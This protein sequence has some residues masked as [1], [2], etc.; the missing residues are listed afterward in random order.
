MTAELIYTSA[1]K[2]LKSGS[3]GFCTVVSSQGMTSNLAQKLESLSAYRQLFPPDSADASKNPISFSHLTFRVGGQEYSVLSRVAAYGTDYSGRTNKIAHHVIPGR[4]EQGSEGPAWILSQQGVMQESWDGQCRNTPQGPSLPSGHLETKVCTGW[5]RLAGDPGWA[6]V[7]AEAWMNPQQK[8]LTV[9][10]PLEHR[11]QSLALLREATALL[12]PSERWRATFCT[13]VTQLPPDVKC[14]VRFVVAGSPDAIKAKAR[15][16]V[17]EL[18]QAN[19]EPPHSQWVEIARGNKVLEKEEPRTGPVVS[20]GSVVE[21]GPQYR[22]PGGVKPG[23][24]PGVTPPRG[25]EKRGPKGPPVQPTPPDPFGLPGPPVPPGGHVVI[26][27]P[28]DAGGKTSRSKS[29]MLVLALVAVAM[30]MFVLVGGAGL[31]I[32]KSGFIQIAQNDSNQENESDST[33]IERDSSSSESKPQTANNESNSGEEGERKPENE[34]DEGVAATSMSEG[35]ASKIK[36]KPAAGD[37]VQEGKDFSVELPSVSVGDALVFQGLVG[38]II[39]EESEEWIEKETAEG[40]VRLSFKKAGSDVKLSFGSE[41]DSEYKPLEKVTVLHQRAEE[42]LGEEKFIFF[43]DDLWTALVATSSD[44]E[45]PSQLD[46]SQLQ[47]S[48]GETVTFDLPEGVPGEISVELVDTSKDPKKYPRSVFAGS[49]ELQE[50]DIKRI[51]CDYLA[52]VKQDALIAKETPNEVIDDATLAISI[53][54]RIKEEVVGKSTLDNIVLRDKTMPV[55]KGLEWYGIQP[56]GSIAR[57]YEEDESRCIYS[58]D[59][60]QNAK[61]MPELLLVSNCVPVK[62]NHFDEASIRNAFRVYLHDLNVPTELQNDKLKVEMFGR[63]SWPEYAKQGFVAGIR[64]PDDARTNYSVCYLRF[65]SR[66]EAAGTQEGGAFF[67]VKVAWSDSPANDGYGISE[68]QRELLGQDLEEWLQTSTQKHGAKLVESSLLKGGQLQANLSFLDIFSLQPDKLTA[69]NEA[70]KLT[71]ALKR[72]SEESSLEL[73]SNRATV[74]QTENSFELFGASQE[75]KD[76][77]DLAL[78]IKEGAGPTK[79]D[80]RESKI[81]IVYT[82]G[83]VTEGAGID[84]L[85]DWSENCKKTDKLFK[86]SKT[87]IQQ[88]IKTYWLVNLEDATGNVR[89]ADR[90]SA[91]KFRQDYEEHFGSPSNVEDALRKLGLVFPLA[92]NQAFY[93]NDQTNSVRRVLRPDLQGLKLFNVL[94][95]DEEVKGKSL[96]E[97]LHL[98]SSLIESQQLA[99]VFNDLVVDITQKDKVGVYRLAAPTELLKKEKDAKADLSDGEK[100]ILQSYRRFENLKKFLMAKDDAQGLWFRVGSEDGVNLKDL[101]PK[102]KIP[103]GFGDGKS[104]VNSFCDGWELEIKYKKKDGEAATEKISLHHYL[105]FQ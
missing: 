97:R 41:S 28:S 35:S 56:E 61:R 24:G 88:R 78:Y 92:W 85:V 20:G 53:E 9:V 19:G 11:D 89:V 87:E 66:K 71:F 74:F 50:E 63:Q 59:T 94:L 39:K 21:R 29:S 91:K 49:S 60:L 64:L 27:D 65:C 31:L 23:Q 72:P 73:Q 38:L 33:P 68:D 52:E 12:R 103:Q 79:R 15:G 62:E 101:L 42:Q 93:F 13:Y 98:V 58:T 67:D 48:E 76:G 37:V 7:L 55:I 26:G 40:E 25:G 54:H 22:D 10:F 100:R 83:S 95:S 45:R 104:D 102:I 34:T 1:P 75:L 57:I 99:N 105:D 6:G 14:Q 16:V 96:M 32:Y 30:F 5:Q 77:I 86:L 18:G 51:T 3:R 43:D 90:T 81:R 46:V 82:K 80:L 8:P 36:V 47:I 4:H 2:G 17:I 70:D 69:M 44:S 84:A